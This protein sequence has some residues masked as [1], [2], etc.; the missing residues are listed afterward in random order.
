MFLCSP[1][2]HPPT[3]ISVSS[4]SLSFLS[5]LWAQ[6]SLHQWGG[7]EPGEWDIPPHGVEKALAPEPLMLPAP[8]AAMGGGEGGSHPEGLERGGERTSASL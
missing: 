8:A 4:V 6:A 7:R 2:A 3:A 1:N 5:P